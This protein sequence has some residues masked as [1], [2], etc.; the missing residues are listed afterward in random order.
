MQLSVERRDLLYA[1]VIQAGHGEGVANQVVQML[2][3][4][5]A[6]EVRLRNG[7]ALAT[8]AWFGVDSSGSTGVHTLWNPRLEL[9]NSVP[10]WQVKVMVE[11]KTIIFVLPKA[12]GNLA[13]LGVCQ[14]VT[15]RPELPQPPHYVPPPVITLTWASG[16]N[17]RLPDKGSHQ[18][19]GSTV[20][21]GELRFFPKPGDTN[22]CVQGSS[23]SAISGSKSDATTGP[24]NINNQNNNINQAQNVVPVNVVVNTG[25]GNASGTATATGNQ[26]ASGMQN[27][28][29]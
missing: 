4:G 13:R 28:G 18:N 8:M 1:A 12:C 9:G 15:V 27:N 10:C 23:A 20:S 25:S 17:E 26:D 24:I 7:T 11:S 6:T 19:M 21:S 22:I 5:Q 14:R 29:P 16:A 2:C 3:L